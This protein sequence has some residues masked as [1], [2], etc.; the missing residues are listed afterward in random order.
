[1]RT[2]QPT[3]KLYTTGEAAQL[4]GCSIRRLYVYELLGVVRPTRAGVSRIYTN[5]DINTIKA[6][7]ERLHGRPDK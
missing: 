1:M 4:C 6:Y 3:Q 5:A 2:P 7:R